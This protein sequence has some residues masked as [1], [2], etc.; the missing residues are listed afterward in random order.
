[1][2]PRWALSIL[3]LVGAG[4]AEPYSGWPEGGQLMP[5]GRGPRN[6]GYWSKGSPEH[7][8]ARRAIE[9]ARAQIFADVTAIPAGDVFCAVS[10]R[11]PWSKALRGMLAIEPITAANPVPSAGRLAELEQLRPGE[12]LFTRISKAD[13]IILT[14]FWRNWQELR[15]TG[16]GALSM[17][18]A[19]M[20]QEDLFPLR[21]QFQ[22][23]PWPRGPKVM[24]E[25]DEGPGVMY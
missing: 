1:M 3:V 21:E 5:A 10:P 14:G 4:C 16:A 17:S 24:V 22:R 20:G 15:S 25:I 8:V 2:R 9:A 13:T 23:F 11:A 18:L 7:V 12:I 6:R 19:R